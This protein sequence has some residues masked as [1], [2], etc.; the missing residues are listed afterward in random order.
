[1]SARHLLDIINDVL[2]MSKIEAGKVALMETDVAVGDVLHSVMRI[3]CDR[4]QAA[5][6]SIDLKVDPSLP[7]MR[8]DQR[9]LRQ[10]LINLVSNAVKC[11]PP[12]EKVEIRALR[13][14][15]KG[16]KI[17]VADTG[18]G[19]PEGKMRYVMEPFGQINDPRS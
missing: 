4:A 17:E 16:L 5:N 11:S 2:D 19:I 9:L 6:V 3:M 8:G 13:G 12:G 7:H 1:F 15:D 18:C 10:I 14:D